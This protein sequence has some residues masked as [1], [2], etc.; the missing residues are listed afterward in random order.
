MQNIKYLN[1]GDEWILAED[2]PD[3]DFQFAQIWLSSFV[4]DLEKTIGTNYKK[5]MSVH[6]GYNLKFYYGHN[7]SERISNVILKKIIYEN[8]GEKININIRHVAD[9]FELE[10]DKIFPE[11]ISSLNNVDLATLYTKLDKIHT[12]F[13]TWCWLPNAVDM[14]HGDFTLYLKDILAN[15]IKDEGEINKALV[16]L[17][18]FREKSFI[19]DEYESLIKLAILKK[20]KDTRFE[21]ALK[22]HHKNYF[23]I[24]HVWIGKENLSTIEEYRLAVDELLNNSE[25]EELLFQE[26]KRLS[27]DKKLHEKYLNKLALKAVEKK[28]FAEY[29]EFAFTKAYRR[30]VQLLWAY[31]MDFIFFEI[32]KRLNISITES[33]FMMPFEVINILK[34]EKVSK[35]FKTILVERAKHC[36]YYAEKNLDVM[37]VGDKCKR[38]KN[39]LKTKDH[40]NIIELKGQVAC[41]GKVVG[42]VKI[43]N[44]VSDIN[45]ITEGDILV[46]ISTNPDLVSA[47]KK[48]AAFVTEQGGITSHAAIIAREMKKPCIIGTKIATKVF[49]D[50]DLVEVDAYNGI[51]KIL[52]EK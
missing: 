7:D 49:K 41:I 12:K 32:S 43:I 34:D 5:V 3:I 19:Q 26:E 9:E 33:R 50:G 36:V 29:A 48:A 18:F 28:L 11:F 35:S 17:S 27:D 30:R 13:Y 10:I 2:I 47:M 39:T 23:Y 52:K 37:V 42:I 44:S 40:S 25:P 15:K 21:E 14:F 4:N 22:I 6:S 31:K 24:K 8:L 1:D 46:S 16:A 45:K 38:F 51:V 20:K